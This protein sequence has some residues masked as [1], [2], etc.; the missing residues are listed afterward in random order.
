MKDLI[1]FLRDLER[2]NNREWFQENRAWYDQTRS[3]WNDFCQELIAEV[4]KYDDD[5]ARL[6][7]R[8]C[9]YRINRDT[10]FSKDKSPYKTHLGVFMAKGGKRSMHA[11]YYLHIG[12]GNGKGYP[13]ECMLASGNY[14]YD[15][16]TVKLLREDISYGWEEF[17]HEVL[18]KADPRMVPEMDG[19]LKRVPRE[20][21]ADAPYADWMRMKAYGLGM[22]VTEDFVTAPGL[23]QRA[24]A[25]FESTKPFVDYINRAVDFDEEA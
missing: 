1:D 17:A 13:Y 11:G 21:A 24:A 6:T 12:T 9:T 18:A 15:P 2:N 25:I 23:A 8:D 5:I 22:H 19:A 7:V 16:R 20:Y 14:C 3:R 10:R 4:G